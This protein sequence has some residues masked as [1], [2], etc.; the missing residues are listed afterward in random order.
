MLLPSIDLMGGQAV[1]L[2]GGRHKAL[3]LGEPLGLARRF[4][5]LDPLALVDL[6]AA[7]GQ[8]DNA[9]Q[10][11][12]LLATTP[13]VLGGGIRDLATAIR[14]LDA[15][16]RRI[17][18]GT[19][20]Q[21][22]LLSRLPR[23]RLVAALDAR[24]GEVVVE[25]WR[26]GTGRGVLE[27]MAEL[28]PHVAGFLVT[29]VELE[30]RQTG[31][32]LERVAELVRAAAPCRLTVAGGIRSAAEV[33]AIDRLG[34][35]AQ[36][37]MA[38]HTGS[39]SLAG[40]L[41]ACLVSDRADGLWPTLVVD[42]HGALLGLAWSDS[43]SLHQAMDS[44]RGVYHSRQRGLWVKGE[45]SGCTQ[46][47]LRVGPDCDRDALRFVV[48][49]HGSGFC[50]RGTRSC[51]G[52]DHGLGRLTRRL[53]ERLHEAPP[54]SYT[55]RLLDDPGLLESKLAEEAH[56]L[57]QAERHSHVAEEAADLLYFASVALARSG[58]TLAEVEAVL[59][60]RELGQTR[61]PG[62]AK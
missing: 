16:A 23:D 51:F 55:R 52:P 54:G 27:R 58:V 42:E 62:D 17:V 49:Q 35:D 41:A 32:D 48:R 5:L 31:V 43:Q 2:V 44:R 18:I 7:L 10:V 53:A 28:A 14:W 24:D 4:G 8:G 25:G 12:A 33:A 36:V 3:D 15:G 50:H 30:G 38:L 45:A 57:A 37:G 11:E 56:E 26:R 39:M 13:C 34:A 61:R 29:F 9:G 21:P 22:E 20:A 19:A 1:Q 59:D 47:L 60:R 40:A 46:D 6:D